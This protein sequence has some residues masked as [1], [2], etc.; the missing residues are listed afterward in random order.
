MQLQPSQSR[1]LVPSPMSSQWIFG[2][3]PAV[4]IMPRRGKH[5]H[6]RQ[7]AHRLPSGEWS[8]LDGRCFN[9]GLPSSG[10]RTEARGCFPVPTL[11]PPPR[12]AH[13]AVPHHS[14]ILLATNGQVRHSN[15]QCMPVLPVGQ[16]P[17][18][19]PAPSSLNSNT[20]PPF[21]YIHVNIV[22]LIPPYCGHMYLFTVIDRTS[23]WPEAIPSPPS[24]PPTVPEPYLPAG[25]LI[26]E[27]QP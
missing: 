17:Q 10:A 20:T 5:A 7:P 18:T 4:A 24:L 16:C 3:G 9:K 14:Q 25:S 1:F 12:G 8:S 23:Q 15:G 26:L 21:A 19:C 11:H 27:C 2:N 6:L 22:D 13:D